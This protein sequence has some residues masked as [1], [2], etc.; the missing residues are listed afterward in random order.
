M[1]VSLALGYLHD[2]LLLLKICT[3]EQKQSVIALFLFICVLKRGVGA[4][5]GHVATL[6]GVKMPETEL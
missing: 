6:G 3:C 4:W 2:I 5:V 1:V